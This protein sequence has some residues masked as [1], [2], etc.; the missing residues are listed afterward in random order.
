[1]SALDYGD[2]IYR[3]ASATTLKT[4]DSVYH[5]ALRFITGD[6]YSTHHCILY[7]K[8][9]WPSLATRRD[10]HWFLFIYKA[11]IGSLPTYLNSLLEW[12][13]I[14]YSTRSQDYLMLKPPF[15]YTEF[16]KAAFKCGASHTW[17]TLQ[18]SLKYSSLVPLGRFKSDIS[19]LIYLNCT[20]FI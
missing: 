2:I 4:L 13:T 15:A 11:L 3:N 1:M 12:N 19:T 18:T 16:G 6:S 17:N 10:Q 7:N 9:G 20:C 14:R 5:S 8:V